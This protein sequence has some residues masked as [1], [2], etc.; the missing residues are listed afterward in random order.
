MGDHGQAAT[1]YC[2]REDGI[3]EAS[4]CRECCAGFGDPFVGHQLFALFGPM[5]LPL[6]G[7]G[8]EGST[9]LV[10]LNGLKL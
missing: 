4:G 9:V 5:R 7:I 3:F 2:T 6:G 8:H 10:C 1:G